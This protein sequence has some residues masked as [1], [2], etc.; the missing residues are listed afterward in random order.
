MDGG[1]RL[2]TGD[3]EEVGAGYRF[4]VPCTGQLTGSPDVL[5]NV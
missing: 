5:V 4:R 3:G 1:A 2:E